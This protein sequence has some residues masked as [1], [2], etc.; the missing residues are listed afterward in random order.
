MS[1]P[2]FPPTTKPFKVALV[3]GGIGGLSLA[4]GLLKHG[5]PFHI[6]EAAPF[7]SEIG[8][9]VGFAPNAQRAMGL[10][11]P[12]IKAGYDRHATVNAYEDNQKYFFEFR[13]GMDGRAGSRTEGKK[14]GDLISQPGGP[15][16]GMNMIHR[17]RFLEELVAL[18]P[19]G[20]A[21]F[22]KTLSRVEELDEGV[23]LHFEDGTTAEADAAI[24]CD[25]VRSRVRDSLF[26]E[27]TRA[28]FS[29]K[30]AYRGF[31]PMEAAVELLGEP[32]ARNSQAY[33]GYGGHVLT[34][35][36]ERGKTMNVVAFQ[37]K[38]DGVWEHDMWRLPMRKDDLHR[39][40]AEWSPDVNKILS[41]MQQPDIW[42]LFDHPRLKQ[43]SRG[44]IALIGDAG[45]ATTPHQGSG[46]AMALEDA[47]VLSGLLGITDSKEE[48]P[49]ALQAFS[50]VRTERTMTLVETSRQCGEVY[51][52]LGPDGDNLAQIDANL[53]VRYNWIW[54]EDVAAEGELAKEIFRSLARKIS[55]EA[56]L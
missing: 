56:R 46:A 51:E 7:F 23:R 25:G 53:R 6:Y 17:A 22:A 45:H 43:L 27:R 8:A 29:G 14:A 15:G 4:V 5:V 16:K 33:L 37:T 41:L 10:I 28:V 49:K 34:M 30:Y 42:A 12:R 19:E 9:G 26:G 21:S 24:G 55:F 18:L 40:F 50:I 1:L 3:G 11:D 39:D 13:M 32:L 54:D 36:V 35:P 38:P 48:I 44:K 47:Y 31:V 2:E 52:F 20:C